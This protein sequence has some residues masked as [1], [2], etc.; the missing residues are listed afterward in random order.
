MGARDGAD[1]F[2]KVKGLIA[3]MI[4]K[5]EAAAGAD[6]T[7]KAYCDKELAE[8]KVKQGDKAAEIA[9]LSTSIDQMSARSA[10][11]KIEIAALQKTLADIAASQTEAG[12]LRQDENSEFQT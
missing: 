8:T 2:A 10:Q 9:K 3:D 6:A 4:A 1:P 7:H 11:L 12:K 5:L